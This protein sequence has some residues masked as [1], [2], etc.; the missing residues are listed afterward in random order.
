MTG[1]DLLKMAQEDKLKPKTIVKALHERQYFDDRVEDYYIY[2]NDNMFHRCNENGKLGSKYQDRF[3][4]YKV[5]NKDFEIC[6][7]KD[8]FTGLKWYD[9]GICYASVDCSEKLEPKQGVICADNPKKIEKIT[10]REKTIGFLNG[11]WT[12]R[13]MDKAFAMKINEIINYLQYKEKKE[14]QEG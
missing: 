3:L 13:N 11:E 2:Q 5:L 6:G 12:A 1:I 10:I 8:D 7:V 4:N 14:E 9:D